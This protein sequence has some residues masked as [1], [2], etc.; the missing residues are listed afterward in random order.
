MAKA[1]INNNGKL[2]LLGRG[3]PPADVKTVPISNYVRDLILSGEKLERKDALRKRPVEKAKAKAPKKAKKVAKKS[4]KKAR[5]SPPPA[6]EAPAAEAQA[7]AEAPALDV[8]E[9]SPAPDTTAPAATQTEPPEC[10]GDV[11][12]E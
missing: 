1:A 11:S 2:V 9:T 10:V 3:K 6:T 4:A 7:P 12:G 5:A 8:V